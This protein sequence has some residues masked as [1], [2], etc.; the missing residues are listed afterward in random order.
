MTRSLSPRYGANGMVATSQIQA[1]QAG[2]AILQSGGSAVDAAIAANAALSVLEPHM[3]GVGGDLFAIVWDP[4][5]GNLVGLNASGRSSK[6]LSYEELRRQLGREQHMPGRGI[7]PLTIPAAVDGWCMLH[8]RFGQLDLAE[9]LKPAINL[10]RN[11]FP[12]GM[13][14]AAVWAAAAKDL[15]Q[16]DKL[17]GLLD[18]FDRTYLANG[19]APVAGEH[20][21]NPALA[22]TY[23]GLGIGG[24]ASF[25]EGEIAEELLAY[26]TSINAALNADDFA[27]THGEWVTPLTTNYRGY[28]VYE[29]PP[30]G[31]GMSVLQMLNLLEGYDIS[32]M[33][34]DDANYWH[35]FLEA[36]KL[37]FEDRARYFADPRTY[38]APIEQLL[39]KSYA[40]QRRGLIQTQHAGADYSFGEVAVPGSDTTYLTAA[41][42]NGMMVSLIQS[43]FSPFGTGLV[44]PSLGFALQCRGA[45]F[46]MAPEHPNCYQAG[47]RPFHTIIPAFVCRDNRPLFSFGVM[48]ADM[49]PQGQVEILVNMLDFGLDPQAAGDMPRL[50]HDGGQQPNGQHLD[51]LGITQYEAD[52]PERVVEDLRQRGHKMVAQQPGMAG[53]TGGYQGILCDWERHNYIGASESRLDGAALGY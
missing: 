42:S 24:S 6:N 7:H 15:H 23:E 32:N 20:M 14:T 5:D 18:P 39:S 26:L 36:K 40:E 30:N 11:G 25:Y 47:K 4:K 34:P 21:T 31:Q 43:I 44:P 2:L 13:K 27:D 22:N 48:G 16:D 29:L 49:Q 17:H 52:M 35:V 33:A 51:G 19:Q 53:F 37:A 10:A 8:D 46:S 28:D 12:V 38:D 1:S 9:V 41:D 50:R 45:G 3:C